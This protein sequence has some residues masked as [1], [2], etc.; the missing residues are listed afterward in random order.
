[1]WNGITT[2]EWAKQCKRLIDGYVF[3]K[4]NTFCTTCIS[5]YELLNIIKQV[6]QLNTTISSVDGI[7]KNKCLTGIELS[8][9]QQQLN[10][11]K[12]FYGNSTL[13]RSN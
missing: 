7:G 3:S 5:K 2:L 1:M 6:Y 4:F 9:I 8:N 11:L 13:S 12:E 10:E